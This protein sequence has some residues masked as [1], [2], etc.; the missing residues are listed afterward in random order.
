[1]NY[2]E[3]LIYELFAGYLYYFG[4]DK[5]KARKKSSRLDFKNFRDTKD[6]EY[7]GATLIN[8]WDLLS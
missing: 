1:M 2:Q 5:E 8:P 4:I 7:S 3:K 6:M